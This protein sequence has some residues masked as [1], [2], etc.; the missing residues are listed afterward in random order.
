MV[1]VVG[2]SRYEQLKELL[3]ILAE[4]ID[5]KPGARDMASLA[6]QYRETLREIEE[7]EG[8]E[9]QDDEINDIL[10]DRESNGKSGAVRKDR[11]RLSN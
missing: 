11:A 9:P 4:Q 3:L 10:T 2:Q 5:S 6:R 8:A 7:L 1:N